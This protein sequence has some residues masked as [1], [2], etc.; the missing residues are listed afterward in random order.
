MKEVIFFVMILCKVEDVEN[1]IRVLQNNSQPK[2]EMIF[3]KVGKE[4]SL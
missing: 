4:N 2:N 1:N 3:Y